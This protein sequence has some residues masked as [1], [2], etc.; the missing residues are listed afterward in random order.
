[1]ANGN[2]SVSATWKG[3]EVP[4]DGARV[5]IPA[6]IDIRYDLS[7]QTRIDTIRIDGALRF[8]SDRDTL[9]HVDTLFVPVRS[10]VLEIGTS[11]APIPAQFTARIVIT[12]DRRDAQGNT[13]LHPND[14]KQFGRGV[15]SKGKASIHGAAKE[16]YLELAG[17]ALAGEST[18]TF[19]STPRGWQAGDIIVVAGTSVMLPQAIRRNPSVPYPAYYSDVLA[20]DVFHDEELTINKIEGNTVSFTN[21]HITSGNRNVLRFDHRRP[22]GLTRPAGVTADFAIHVGNLTR[23]VIIESENGRELSLVESDEF[24]MR[25]RNEIMK[26][27]HAMFMHTTDADI[28]N[29]AFWHLGRTDKHRDLDEVG[30]QLNGVTGTG[31]NQRGRYAVHFHRT[32]DM[33]WL[34][35]PAII[36]GCA[37]WGSPGWGIRQRNRDLAT[38]PL[39]QDLWRYPWD[40]T[41][42]RSP[43]QYLH[44]R[45]Q[46]QSHY[47]FRLWI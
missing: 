21:N 7:S 36:R 30:V 31:T 28:V 35:T 8:A 37:I 24:P 19:A 6:G 3:G 11:T 20:N 46:F 10:G 23:N 26:R 22:A 39:N 29:A 18:L 27:G 43:A 17:D 41:G 45:H 2:W 40:Y 14:L 5:L 4:G 34:G 9:L 16:S 15:I 42:P 1:M 44:L 25:R 13:I 33:Q 38:E 47:E 32:G 12:G